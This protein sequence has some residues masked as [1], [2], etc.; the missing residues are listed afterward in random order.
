MSS[1]TQYSNQDYNLFLQI[2]HNFTHNNTHFEI[3]DHPRWGIIQ[4][5]VAN[6]DLKA[7]EELFGY[8]GYTTSK[9]P[10]DFPWYYDLKAKV[11]KEKRLKQAKE[12][13]MK[14]KKKQTV[15]KKS[16]EN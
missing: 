12:K 8:Y 9:F 10:D 11:E 15:K 5:V 4:G 2:N 3:I 7:G 14:K 16:K 13:M 6:R 1:I